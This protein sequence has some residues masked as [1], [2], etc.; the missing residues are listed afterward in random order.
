MADILLLGMA[1][2]WP[3]V[4]LTPGME[5]FSALLGTPGVWALPYLLI[6]RGGPEFLGKR[7]TVKKITV[8]TAALTKFNSDPTFLVELEEIEQS[9]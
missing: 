5:G 7:L 4:D 1:P 8:Y 9:A 2:E 6:Q 3:G